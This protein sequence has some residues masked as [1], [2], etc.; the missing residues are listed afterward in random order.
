MI[1]D[2]QVF[3]S[4]LHVPI[5][6]YKQ[7]L[8]YLARRADA[9]GISGYQEEGD[10]IL[11]PLY[12]SE[13]HVEFFDSITRQ[14]EQYHAFLLLQKVSC[15]GSCGFRH[16]CRG[17]F[18]QWPDGE[19]MIAFPAGAKVWI[20]GGVTDIVARWSGRSVLMRAGVDFH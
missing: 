17:A 10:I 11:P 14:L 18:A 5:K 9:C 3:C 20:A 4:R 8:E 15:D 19:A 12:D 2:S 7:A 16:G 1:P 13:A 6:R